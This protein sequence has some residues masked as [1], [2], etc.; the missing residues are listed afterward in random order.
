VFSLPIGARG[1]DGAYFAS[2]GVKIHYTDSKTKKTNNTTVVLLHGYTM[3]MGMWHSKGFVEALSQRYRVITVDFRGHG[4]S[5]KPLT[6]AEYGPKVGE[7]VIHL[8]DH[9]NIA[10]AHLVGY[11]M[12]AYVAGRLLVTHPER[13]LSATLGSGTFPIASPEEQAFQEETAKEMEAHGEPHLASVAR[14]WA[15]DAVSMQE[16]AAITVPVQAIYGSEELGHSYEGLKRT[17]EAPKSALPMLVIQGAD[18]DSE[19]AAVLHPE[20]LQAVIKLIDSI[21]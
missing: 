3:D 10:K 17:L 9:L 5:D 13:V 2:S 6:P 19:K 16:V 15:A 1:V 18:H 20:F 12:G 7:D 8:L 14:G 21:N 4:K 11:S